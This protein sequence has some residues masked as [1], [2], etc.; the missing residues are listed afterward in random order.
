M[1]KNR[2]VVRI[3]A[4]LVF[5]AS[6]ALAQTFPTKPI[7]VVVPFPPGGTPDILGRILGPTLSTAL[8][9]PVL[10]DNRGGAAGNIGMEDVA[11]S[12][13]DGHTLAVG[14]AGPLSIN[15]ALYRKMP[16]DSVKDFTPITLI[17]IVPNVMVV[18]PSVPAKSVKELIALAKAKP[19]SL[20][21]GSAGVGSV[22]FMAVEYFKQQTD[23]RIVPIQYRGVGAMLP[24]LIAGHIQM[25]MAGV[26]AFLPFIKASR[27]RALAVSADKRIGLLPDVPTFGELGFPKFNEGVWFGILGPANMPPAVIAKL[28][29]EIVKAVQSPEVVNQYAA[30]GAA[31]ATTTPREMRDRIIAEAAQWASVIK[32]TGVKPE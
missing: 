5:C 26:T 25:S 24:D 21:Y 19:G 11:R 32:A 2:L 7:R 13:P 4:A 20:D 18:H 17:A 10:I 12:A 22:P 31:A 14:N 8:G 16:Y 29:S 9:Q 27:L 3:S 28:H 30:Q 15:P 1:Y 6:S 23:T